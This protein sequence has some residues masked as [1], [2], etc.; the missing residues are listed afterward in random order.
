MILEQLGISKF[1]SAT[2]ISS[3]VGADKPEALIFERGLQL[4]GVRA[5]EALHVGDDPV[6]DWEGATRA[7]LCAFQLARPEKSLRDVLAILG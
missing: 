7:G 2:V 5:D 3:E 1:F 4:T 6:K